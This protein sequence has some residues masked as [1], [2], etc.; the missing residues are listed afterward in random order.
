MVFLTDL[1]LFHADE[2]LSLDLSVS[3]KEFALLRVVWV[4]EV[5]D[6]IPGEHILPLA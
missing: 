2:S 1:Y 6:P 4:H 3:E 5:C